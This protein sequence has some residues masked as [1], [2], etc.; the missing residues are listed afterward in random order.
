MDYATVKWLHVMSATL[1]FGTGIGSAFYLL[2]VSLT[3][4]PVAVAAV[5]RVVVIA[6]TLFTATT[7]VIQPLTGFHLAHLA[8]LGLETRWLLWSTALY[9]AAIA[10]W[11][12]VVV[13]QIRLRDLAAQARERRAPLPP[14]YWR[15]LLAWVLLGILALLAFVSIFY[16]MVRKPV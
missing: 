9:A 12:P 4:D 16:L 6:D 13:I 10:C 14:R 7:A 15:N 2:T 3:R 8:G 11:L 1:L 5:A